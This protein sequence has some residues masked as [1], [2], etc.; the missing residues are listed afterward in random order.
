MFVRSWLAYLCL[1]SFCL[2]VCYASTIDYIYIYKFQTID[3]SLNCL[4]SFHFAKDVFCWKHICQVTLVYP[5]IYIHL[6]IYTYI[7]I[8]IYISKYPQTFK[9]CPIRETVA[10]YIYVDI[11]I[12]I[13][14][15]IQLY[16]SAESFAV[17]QQE[18]ARPDHN[19]RS[20]LDAHLGLLPSPWTSCGTLQSEVNR[21][22]TLQLRRLSGTSTFSWIEHTR[23]ELS[24]CPPAKLYIYI[25]IYIYTHIHIGRSLCSYTCICEY[26]YKNISIYITYIHIYKFYLSKKTIICFYVYYFLNN[27]TYTHLFWVLPGCS[28]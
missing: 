9:R 24:S 25:W 28:A 6:Y 22:K 8:Y 23:V 7:Y 1:I 26:K 19:S 15:S 20:A 2:T 14:K 21:E 11:D 5:Y 4:A 13:Y 18:L 12:Y 27:D 10:C 17:G 3:A 16:P